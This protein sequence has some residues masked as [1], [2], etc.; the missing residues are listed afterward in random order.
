MFI[1]A[2]CMIKRVSLAALCPQHIT[3]SPSVEFPS[4]GMVLMAITLAHRIVPVAIHRFRGIAPPRIKPILEELVVGIIPIERTG[5]RIVS[6]INRP[7]W[8]YPSPFLEIIVLRTELRIRPDRNHQLAVHGMERICQSLLVGIKLRV[9]L[10]LS[11]MPCRPVTPILYYHIKRNLALAIFS[12]DALQFPGTA[13]A[14]LR[15]GIA[16]KI[17]RHH[18]ALT[19]KLAIIGNHLI[20]VVSLHHVII[21]FLR[22]FHFHITAICHIIIYH[23]TACIKKQAITSRRVEH[24]YHRLQVVLTKPHLLATQVH[25]VLYMGSQAIDSLIL[26]PV[27][28][29]LIAIS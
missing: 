1:D 27:E 15:L 14:F 3:Q 9:H 10:H 6:V 11:P 13:I 20:H 25:V 8:Q 7:T 17:L 28:V 5:L 18:R 16:E 29:H 24:R 23:G 21:N 4:L 2:H 12:D 26:L 19:C 22:S